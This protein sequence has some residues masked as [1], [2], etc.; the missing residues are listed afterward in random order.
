MSGLL[1]RK[2]ETSNLSTSIKFKV[3]RERRETQISN[4]PLFPMLIQ[5]RFNGWKLL[6]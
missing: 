3:A 1:V 6:K 2:L 4:M 5:T